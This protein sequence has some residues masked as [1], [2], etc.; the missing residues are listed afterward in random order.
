MSKFEQITGLL[1]LLFIFTG[2]S[3]ENKPILQTEAYSWYPDRIEQGY[4]TA[5]ALSETEI[6]S[7]YQ[8][9]ENQYHSPVANF[10][11][12]INGEDNEMKSGTDHRFI[13]TTAQAKTPLIVFGEPLKEDDKKTTDVFLRPGT[14]WTVRLDMRNMFRD[15]ETK[16]FYTTPKGD[17]IHKEDFKGVYI[18][19]DIPPLT[20]DFEE[21][22]NRPD[23]ELHDPDGDGIYETTFVLNQP[24]KEK[25]VN[26]WTLKNKIDS[27]PQYNSSSVLET[28]LYNMS[29]DEMVNAIEPDS[30]LRTGKEWS[31]VWT[32]DVSYS[33][34]LSMAYMQPRVSM[35]SL[36][37]K[38][39][40]KGRII[41]DTGTGGAWPCSSDRM[42]WAVAAWEIYKVTGSH[43]W[44]QIIY[45]IIKNSMEDD[46]LTVYDPETG[47][48]R[49]ESSFI[50]WRKQS[51]PVW[52]EPVDIYKSQC[53]GTNI[54][55]VE[56]LR[57][58]S[59]IATILEFEEEAVAYKEKSVDL[60]EAVHKHLW[61][62]EKG[63]HGA[64]LYGR[65]HFTLSPPQ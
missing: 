44:L 38:V 4:Y 28:A 21:L 49:G 60:T 52:M 39:N 13:I 56:A 50:D 26:S 46:F 51:Y 16:G 9:P 23:L 33:I 62:E 5:T 6:V 1:Y 8:S 59:R 20:W 24:A 41:Q 22:K 19:G 35:N 53:L 57:V 32:R 63:Y 7:D 43:E 18:A 47:L 27:Y 3:S 42:I 54:V 45:P 40:S 10:K 12:A 17:T 58:L 36:I 37:H 14:Q 30:T 48:V 55:H 11:F 29:L 34:I 64:Y 31:G 65:N 2:C 25:T 15:F 61:M